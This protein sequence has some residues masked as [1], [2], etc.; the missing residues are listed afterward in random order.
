MR[1]VRDAHPSP[2]SLGHQSRLPPSLLSPGIGM[3]TTSVSPTV[4]G[5]LHHLPRGRSGLPPFPSCPLWD[6]S[7]M[8]PARLSIHPPLSPQARKVTS[9][10]AR[11]TARP[12]CAAPATSGPRS[13]SRCCG[14]GRCA[15]GTGGKE[16]TG[17]RSSSAARVPRGWRVACSESTAPPTRP[18]CTRA[19][20]TEP[21]TDGRD[22]RTDGQTPA[23]P[24]RRLF[25]KGTTPKRL[26]AVRYCVVNTRAGT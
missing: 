3:S 26:V 19:S 4:P 11:R 18:A 1:S 9:A 23:P 15:P 12:G 2:L 21:P 25:L 6:R 17:W 16:P 14:R 7:G 24:E 20:G 8:F 22:G 13:A 5:L 10:C